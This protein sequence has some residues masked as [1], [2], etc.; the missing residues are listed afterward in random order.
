[1][2]K[3]YPR[4][5]PAQENS[6]STS[7]NNGRASD[8]VMELWTSAVLRYRRSA[9]SS[10]EREESPEIARVNV[11]E[12]YSNLQ[13]HSR[14]PRRAEVTHARVPRVANGRLRGPILPRR[15]RQL[16]QTV[17]NDT[18]PP[19]REIGESELEGEL[20][21]STATYRYRP[22]PRGSEGKERCVIC[23]SDLE[24]DEEVRRLRC[25]H[26]FHVCC[27]DQWLRL[28]RTCPVCRQGLI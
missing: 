6:I 26:F 28:N 14:W 8:A 11:R 12:T 25:L 13:Q 20:M 27:I 10:A 18:A 21:R 22:D 7:E 5:I 19:R 2:K 15:H 16:R 17:V 23:L 9:V 24:E 1:M 3:K 4:M